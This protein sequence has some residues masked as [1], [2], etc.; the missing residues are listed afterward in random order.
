MMTRL[1]Q[2]PTLRID[3]AQKVVVNYKGKSYSGSEGDTVAT[4]L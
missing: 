1:N 4:A 2:L 3:T